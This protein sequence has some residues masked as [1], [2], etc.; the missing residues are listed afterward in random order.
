MIAGMC[1]PVHGVRISILQY[2]SDDQPGFVECE[3]IDVTGR[4][5]SFIEKVPVVTT[6][7]LHAQSGYPQPDVIACEVLERRRAPDGTTVVTIDTE[8]PC[9]IATVAGE[10]RFEVA[11]EL[12]TESDWG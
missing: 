10:T 1:S 2:V 4:A 6:A 7:N 3:L 8:R 9:G 11:A 12:L 5:W